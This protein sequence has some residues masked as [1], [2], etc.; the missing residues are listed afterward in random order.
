MNIDYTVKV[1]KEGSQYVAHAAPLDVMSSG[2]TPEDARNAL[3]E[4]VC[5]FIE[6]ARE[7][8]TL[9]DILDECG[10]KFREDERIGSSQLVIE[11]QPIPVGA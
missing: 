2:A 5:L 8:E 1:W 3:R 7:M 9:E 4:A 6:T 10:Y 11:E